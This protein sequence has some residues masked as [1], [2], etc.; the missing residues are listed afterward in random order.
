MVAHVT[1]TVGTRFAALRLQRR[2]VRISLSHEASATLRALI[3]HCNSAA[4]V[5]VSGNSGH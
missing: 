1:A 3:D 2:G 4:L 5:G